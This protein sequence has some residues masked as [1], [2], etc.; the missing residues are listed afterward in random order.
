MKIRACRGNTGFAVH[1]RNRPDAS[2]TITTT[3]TELQ[4][5]LSRLPRQKQSLKLQLKPLRKQ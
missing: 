1:Y 4:R 2:S 5:L 3:I